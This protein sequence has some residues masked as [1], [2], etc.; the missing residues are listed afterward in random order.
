MLW[1]LSAFQQYGE[2]PFHLSLPF[3][4]KDLDC[5]TWFSRQPMKAW[6]AY[7]EDQP[8]EKLP[9]SETW[10]SLQICVTKPL[11][12]SCVLIV[13]CSCRFPELDTKVLSSLILWTF[14]LL[15]SDHSVHIPSK[16]SPLLWL[17]GR[18]HCISQ[19]SLES[20]MWH[21]LPP[22]IFKITWEHPLSCYVLNEHINTDRTADLDNYIYFFSSSYHVSAPKVILLAEEGWIKSVPN[23]RA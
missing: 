2:G 4:T 5:E 19:S 22:L 6:L 10:S 11:E 14:C 20:D 8:T 7:I 9:F 16:F 23:I 15:C 18:L 12:M 3:F 21:S 13:V 1:K 17:C